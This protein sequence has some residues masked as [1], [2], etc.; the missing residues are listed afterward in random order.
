M[1]SDSES[2]GGSDNLRIIGPSVVVYSLKYR[3]DHML[4]NG[5]HFLLLPSF[6][7]DLNTNFSR[8]LI[9]S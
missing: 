6:I 7:V 3:A 2:T 8:R 9:L 4:I 1:S 5:V